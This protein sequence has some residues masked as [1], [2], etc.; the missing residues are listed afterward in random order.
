MGSSYSTG[1]FPKEF[2]SL[3]N[4]DLVVIRGKMYRFERSVDRNYDD[5]FYISKKQLQWTLQLSERQ[6]YALF[7]RFNTFNRSKIPTIE[8]WGA[9]ILCS[10]AEPRE[11]VAFLFTLLDYN[12]D[13]CL[14]RTDMEIL[15]QCVTRGLSKFKQI[16]YPQLKTV[17]RVVRSLFANETSEFNEHGD[18]VLKSCQVIICYY[19]ILQYI[20]YI[21]IGFHYV[22]YIP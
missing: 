2:K 8:L 10:S 6:T 12:K 3:I 15:I 21:F 5:I 14:S 9:L 11:K 18:I 19:L 20:S 13:N 7:Q 22:M 17:T 4:L 1:P 16:Q